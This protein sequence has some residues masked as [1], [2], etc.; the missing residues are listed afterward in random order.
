MKVIWTLFKQNKY[1]NILNIVVSTVFS[2]LLVIL[3]I[4]IDQSNIETGAVQNFKDKN[5]YQISD[6]LYGEKE[7]AF[8]SEESNYDILHDFSKNLSNS[9]MFDYYSAIWQPIEV[10]DFKGDN[11][12]DPYYET[13]DS[14]PPYNVN[15]KSYSSV[16]SMRFNRTVFH[17]NNIQVKS[18]R[19]FENEE[20]IFHE[21]NNI[22]PIILG[23][24][25]S[26]LYA[27]GDNI[28]IQYYQKVFKGTIIGFFS[29]FQKV[30]ANN[31]PEILLD[32]YM[33]LPVVD[34]NELPTS[35]MKSNSHDE[36][37]FRATLL[38]N[39]NGKIVTESS[40]LEIRTIF[41]DITLET[42]FSD[43]TII[44]ANSISIDLLVKMIEQ[45]RMT[46]YI[47]TLLLFIVITIIYI[48]TMYLKI[49][50]NT[51]TFLVLLIS[52]S[53]LNHIYKIVSCEFIF[54]NVIGS[55]IPITFLLFLT[56]G[57]TVLLINYLFIAAISIFISTI[58]ISLITKKTFE[59]IDMVQSLKG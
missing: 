35:M 38:T 23:S 36:T 24:D 26:E 29:P 54:T 39:S 30:M 49:K 19:T 14:Q 59:N 25:F 52:G 57:P 9:T 44:G 1:L 47:V 15:G 10:A 27:L 17:L 45:N 13:G 6:S 22:V 42:A 34:F 7:V 37:F 5:L 41:D 43:F 53:N 33:I 4:N 50:R 12:F 48:F 40:P 20:Y 16:K 58:V 21:N 18:G 31:E 3:V 2:F 46:L 32:R 51:D 11:I 8:L 56:K 28:E 55:I